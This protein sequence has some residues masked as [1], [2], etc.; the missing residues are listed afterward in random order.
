VG[1]GEQKFQTTFK[2]IGAIYNAFY[3]YFKAD[4]NYLISEFH[5][6]D[7][8]SGLTYD[9]FRAARALSVRSH[10]GTVVVNDEENFTPF[11]AQDVEDLSYL[12]LGDRAIN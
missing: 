10:V 3:P 5:K 7:K 9:N 11:D 12:L 8:A 6:N 1:L 2:E 4:R